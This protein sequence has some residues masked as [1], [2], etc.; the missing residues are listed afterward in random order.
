MKKI[1]AMLMLALLNGTAM[2]QESG[3]YKSNVVAEEGAWCWFADP[4]ALHY[5]NAAGTINAIAFYN[6]GAEK[7]RKFDLYLVHT[8]KSEF[9]DRNDWIPASEAD[10]VFS[11]EVT[12]VTGK[13]TSI[14]LD[15]PFEYD[16][17]SNLAVIVDDNTGN[18]SSKP[19]MECLVYSTTA[20]QTLYAHH[21]KYNFDPLALPTE[22]K[23]NE[24]TKAL[25]QK[26]QLLFSITSTATIVSSFVRFISLLFYGL[27]AS[28]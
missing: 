17:T 12:L 18:K 27:H 9:I 25:N 14:T 8:E 23:G 28:I 15:T 13:W 4:R 2:A 20:S 7:S 24:D 1:L 16:G 19:H 5:E 3:N 10:M 11:G 26:N 22:S 6:S 21:N